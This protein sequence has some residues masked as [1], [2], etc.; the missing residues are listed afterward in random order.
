MTEDL[1][2]IGSGPA[3][4]TA[5][6]Y[7]ARAGLH[8]L[9]VEGPLPGGQLTT[10]TVIENF[11]GCGEGITG[12][13]LM[14]KMRAQA[15]R[16]G[17]RFQ[18]GDVVHVDF[19]RQPLTITFRE[20]QTKE[21]RAVIIATG[22]SPR[23]LGLPSESKLLGRG[24]SVCATCDGPFFRGL[25][26][27]V[28]GGG[29]AAMEE[30]LYLANLVS[31]VTVIHRRD[32]FRASRIMAERVLRHPRVSVRWDT[33]VED[34]LDVAKNQVTGLRLRNVKTGDVSEL[35]VAGV[36]LAIGHAPNSQPFHGHVATDARGYILTDRTRTHV[37]GVFAAGDVQDPH[38]RQAVT[39]AGSGCIAALEAERYLRSHPLA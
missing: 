34:I 15:Q 32:A 23:Y 18:A 29:D 27:A 22:A 10:T 17:A 20:G 9:V 11:P 5:A 26:V 19:R 14:E 8:P 36:F 21:S 7:A 4:L 35:P 13:E 39:A 30:T 6:L 38:Y 28:V 24:V 33:V 37:E 1:L 12:G 2:I 25:P 3:G 31:H 16:F